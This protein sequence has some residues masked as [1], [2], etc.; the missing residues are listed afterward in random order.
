MDAI[1]SPFHAGEREAQILSGYGPQRAAPIRDILPEQHR[2]F[3]P[4]LPFLPLATLDGDGAPIA[5]IL[6]GRQGFVA[7]PDPHTLTVA[8]RPAGDDPAAPFLV[9]GA[10]VGLLGIDLSTRRRNRANGT[11]V[12]A[13]PAGFAI[14]VR[15]SFGNCP[16]YIQGR[17]AHRVSGTNA[18]APAVE[19]FASLDEEARAQIVG[20]DT[21]FVASASRDAAAPRGGVDISHRGGRPGFV[22]VDGATLTIPDF[23]GNRYF[24]T[25][26]NLLENPRAA[27]LF[28]DFESGD[29]LTLQGA[30]EIFWHPDIA[31]EPAFEG[32]ERL[33]R[34][35]A[36][37]G[38]RRRRAL[39]LRWT[40]R[41]SAPQFAAMGRRPLPLGR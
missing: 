11:I 8:A 41:D 29:V 10:P 22:R 28:V 6:E 21:F 19:R 18:P 14:D 35:T 17:E 27:L 20:A 4:L 33:W 16:Q 36:E 25:L 24:N 1:P 38:W 32:A 23:R 30:T 2:A 7:S 3:F 12:A 26:G 15:Q 39:S 37:K 9:A 40:F 5:T 31:G 13:E 34:F